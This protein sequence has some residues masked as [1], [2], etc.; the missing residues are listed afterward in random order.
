[1]ATLVIFKANFSFKSQAVV[2]N[3]DTLG[4]RQAGAGWDKPVI[5]ASRGSARRDLPTFASGQ[6]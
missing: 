2:F 5:V 3:P 6:A 1:M 4:R